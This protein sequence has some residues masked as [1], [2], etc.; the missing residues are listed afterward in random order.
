MLSIYANKKLMNTKKQ[1]ILK[2]KDCKYYLLR[3]DNK[4][5]KCENSELHFSIILKL[6]RIL[7][8]I[9]NTNKQ[10]QNYL[11]CQCK[12]WNSMW[13]SWVSTYVWVYIKMCITCLK[14]IK[15]LY[16]YYCLCIS[17]CVKCLKLN[18]NEVWRA[19]MVVIISAV[20]LY[21]P[22]GPRDVLYL[23]PPQ[24]QQQQLDTLYVLYQA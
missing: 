3:I 2:I 1:S 24:L 12:Q 11:F 23:P 8:C 10:T 17:L 19:P 5:A 4:N 18:E 16:Y 9:I 13:L 22:T 21:G 15:C 6:P 7:V 14:D 20:L